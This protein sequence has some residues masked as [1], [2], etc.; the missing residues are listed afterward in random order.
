MSPTSPALRSLF[1]PLNPSIHNHKFIF[2]I[3]DSLFVLYKFICT[4]FLDSTYKQYHMVFVFLYDLLHS[5]WQ[6]LDL[7]MLVQLALFHFFMAEWYSI[8]YV[9]H[10]LHLFLCWWTFRL[11]SCPSY[12][13]YCCSEHWVCA[14]F[15][16]LV[17]SG[18]THRNGI[19]ESYDTWIFSFS[20]CKRISILFCVM[21]VPIYIPTNSVGGCSFL[22]I[23]PSIYCL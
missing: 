18:Y 5:V 17:F 1:P 20:F 11:L 16:I 12:C 23:L 8:I 4:S 3:C 6:S 13:K 19:T 14:D 22:H 21:A 7:Y 9:T 15:W 10:L 2:Y